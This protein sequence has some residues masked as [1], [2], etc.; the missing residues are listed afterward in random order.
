MMLLTRTTMAKAW[1][2]TQVAIIVFKLTDNIR[3][4]LPIYNTYTCDKPDEYLALH[5][6]CIVFV[7]V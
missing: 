1:R 4:A 7:V 5:I 2:K 6:A 3:Q